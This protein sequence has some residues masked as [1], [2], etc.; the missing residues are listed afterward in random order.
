MSLMKKI[1]TARRVRA[2][3]LALRAPA[4]HRPFDPGLALPW[5][6]RRLQGQSSSSCPPKTGRRI[7]AGSNSPNMPNSSACH[8]TALGYTEGELATGGEL[9]RHARST[10]SIR[11][12]SGSSLIPIPSP[13][14][15]FWW[16]IAASAAL[17]ITAA[18]AMA[19]L[20]RGRYRSPF[21]WGWHDPFWGSGYDVESCTLL[22]QLSSI[23]TSAARADNELLFEGHAQARSQLN[24]LPRAG[25]RT[26]SSGCSPVFPVIRA[27]RCGSRCC[28][29][30]SR[31]GDSKPAVDQ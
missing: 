8:L 9:R 1:L 13:I 11:A 23:S 26:W 28:R 29:S 15:F 6:C 22:H 14:L 4:R 12:G 16:P 7:A 31:G 30:A 24:E 17:P 20:G 27:R 21:Y 18:S 25:A 3:L 19:A 10:A 2:L 5:R